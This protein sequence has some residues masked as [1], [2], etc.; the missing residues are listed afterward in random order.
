MKHES[1]GNSTNKKICFFR[2]DYS[3]CY[4]VWSAR[5]SSSLL[6]L[7]AAPYDFSKAQL[8]FFISSPNSSLSL[9]MAER[10]R[11]LT[12]PSGW[13]RRSAISDCVSPPK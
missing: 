10:V 7:I 6:V 4:F 5:G 9:I 12:V 3:S 8:K 1:T 13:L 11:V 2:V